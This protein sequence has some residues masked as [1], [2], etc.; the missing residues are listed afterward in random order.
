[1]K[2]INLNLSVTKM[3]QMSEEFSKMVIV[4]IEKEFKDKLEGSSRLAEAFEELKRR[5]KRKLLVAEREL[6]NVAKIF[7]DF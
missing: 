6:T 7:T 3:V 2:V 4:E 5:V 1:M